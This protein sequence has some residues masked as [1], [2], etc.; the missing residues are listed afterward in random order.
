SMKRGPSPNPEAHAVLA[1]EVAVVAE[2]VAAIAEAGAAAV[3]R[4]NFRTRIIAKPRASRAS[5][6]G[7]TRILTFFWMRNRRHLTGG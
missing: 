7:S 6:A 3:V 4:K 1:A 5:L 2:T